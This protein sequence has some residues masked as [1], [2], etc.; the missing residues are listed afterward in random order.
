MWIKWNCSVENFH[1]KSPNEART[2]KAHV[3]RIKNAVN[4]LP[5]GIFFS[6]VQDLRTGLQFILPA[7]FS[8]T[9]SGIRAI[10]LLAVCQI[11]SNHA[12]EWMF[13]SPQPSGR[14]PLRFSIKFVN[15]P[16]QFL[17]GFIKIRVHNC[18]VKVV[19]IV[20]LHLSSLLNDFSQL[21]RLWILALFGQ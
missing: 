19:A 3:Q 5:K 1:L 12:T 16:K 4:E 11:K 20:L 15:Q 10:F 13:P 18:C 6:L 8:E 21:F 7:T 14:H 17:I 9:C 2:S